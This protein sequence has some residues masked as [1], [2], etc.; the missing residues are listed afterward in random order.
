MQPDLMGGD[1][2]AAGD[3]NEMIFKVPS[4]IIHSMIL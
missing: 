1:Q 4:D 2:P 3:W